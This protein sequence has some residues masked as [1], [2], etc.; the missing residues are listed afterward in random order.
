MSQSVGECGCHLER[1]DNGLRMVDCPLHSASADMLKAINQFIDEWHSDNS[2][3]T[4]P[5]PES[6]IMMR[7]AKAKA[8]GRLKP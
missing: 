1:K 7:K 8:E 4:S 6:L 5:E 2:N 3:F